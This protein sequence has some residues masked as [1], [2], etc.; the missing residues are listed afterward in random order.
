MIHEISPS[1]R[2]NATARSLAM[3]AHGKQWSSTPATTLKM[4]SRA[5]PAYAGSKANRHH[6]RSHRSCRR[7]NE[8]ARGYRRA[9][10][11]QSK[12]L[13]PAHDA[14]RAGRLGRPWQIWHG[15][16][17][18]E[19]VNTGDTVKAGAHTANV[20]PHS[21]AHRRQHL[22]VLRCRQKADRGRHAVRWLH[23]SH[24]SSRRLDA[25]DLCNPSTELCS[26]CRT[27]R[28]WFRATAQ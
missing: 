19:R 12:R 9:N 21:G 28:S 4:C 13:C 10:P 23:R 22:P 1:G 27:T 2:C 15:R 8:A 20:L 16:D 3:R 11:S 26:L 17:R 25:E 6:A 7:R 18:P 5:P 24:G 14:R